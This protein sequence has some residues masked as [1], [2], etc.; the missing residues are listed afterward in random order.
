MNLVCGHAITVRLIFY[1]LKS[2]LLEKRLLSAKSITNPQLE[3]DILRKLF[4][5]S[6]V[7]RASGCY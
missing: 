6:S 5:G 7:G 4:L 2:F 1:M 3:E